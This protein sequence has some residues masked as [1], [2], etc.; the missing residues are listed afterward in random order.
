MNLR[1]LKYGVI[2]FLC[3]V[4]YFFIMSINDFYLNFNLRIGN[5][6]FHTVILYFAIVRFRKSEAG[7]KNF[8][9]I[10]GFL[11][12]FKPSIIASFLFS[13]FQFFYLLSNP[14]FLISLK[15]NAPIGEYLTPLTGS[16][17]I[18]AEGVGVS[19]ILSYIIMRIVDNNYEGQYAPERSE[20]SE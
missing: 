17:I 4:L 14:E 9:Y 20:R 13:L 7:S 8:N 5:V 6:I 12:G 10:T 18:F 1:D 19:L 2:L 15:E 16:I 3:F 11:A